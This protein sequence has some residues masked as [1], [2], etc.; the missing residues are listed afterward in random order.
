MIKPLTPSCQ[1][2]KQ[3]ILAF[4]LLGLFHFQIRVA[5]M[6]SSISGSQIITLLKGNVLEGV[7][8]PGLIGSEKKA[9]DMIDFRF[10][11][12][13]PWREQ[14]NLTLSNPRK[15]IPFAGQGW[16]TLPGRDQRF[17]ICTLEATAGLENE[18]FMMHWYQMLLILFASSLNGTEA[19]T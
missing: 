19:V 11:V 16:V 6:G 17:T 8:F 4:Q 13:I 14:N 7:S 3:V 9:F 5:C 2:T 1:Y 12:R 10:L 18:L 15:H